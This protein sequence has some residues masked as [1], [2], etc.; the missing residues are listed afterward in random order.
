MLRG[1]SARRMTPISHSIGCPSRLLVCNISDDSLI[2]FVSKSHFWV[3]FLSRS[4]LFLYFVVFPQCFCC[5]FFLYSLLTQTHTAGP[6]VDS[7]PGWSLWT[8]NTSIACLCQTI[9]CCIS[10]HLRTQNPCRRISRQTVIHPHAL[11][12]RAVD[13]STGRLCCTMHREIGAGS[14]GLVK[15]RANCSPNT[16]RVRD[17]VAISHLSTYFHRDAIHH[18]RRNS[19]SSKNVKNSRVV[20]RTSGLA[21][22]AVHPSP[23]N[24]PTRL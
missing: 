7:W 21:C 5:H 16:G 6:A 1:G 17:H 3:T 23:F 13:S 9:L 22:S 19:S 11:T 24:R 12:S 8:N 15:V 20:I 4:L 10:I 2:Y 14:R 18:L